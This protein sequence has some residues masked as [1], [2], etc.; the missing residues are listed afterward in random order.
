VGDRRGAGEEYFAGEG[1]RSAAR[2]LFMVG[3]FK[4]AIFGFQGTD[5]REFEARARASREKARALRRRATAKTDAAAGVPRPVDRRSFRSAPPVLDVGRRGD[6]EVGPERWAC[7]PPNPHR[8]LP[9]RPPGSV[10]LWQPFAPRREDEEAT[11]GARKAGSTSRVPRYATEL[12]RQ[13][14]AW[15][16]EAP[17]LAS[18]GGRCAPATS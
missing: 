18:T 6:R 5:P 16:D 8:S 2:T 17:V 13:V 1:A 3:D 10:E 9:P 4:Q 11:R 14:K 12:A 7:R 15:L